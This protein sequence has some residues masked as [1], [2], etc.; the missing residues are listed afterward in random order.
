MTAFAERR[1]PCFAAPAIDR[2][3]SSSRSGSKRPGHSPPEAAP[4]GTALEAWLV[5]VP[6]RHVTTVADLTDAEAERWGS[7]QVRLSRALH[8]AT[9]CVKT[10]IVQ[11][12][13]AEGFAHVHFHIV[14]RA[15]TH[16]HDRRGPAAFSYLSRPQHEQVTTRQMDTLG[17]S[18]RRAL[19]S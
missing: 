13:E 9:G 2:A 12:A 14:P 8:T 17:E 5:L 16:P 7:W 18:L 3:R 15:M 6:R 19:G 10:Y 1:Q 4:I 11:F